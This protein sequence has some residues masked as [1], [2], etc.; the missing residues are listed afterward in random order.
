MTDT[1]I[2]VLADSMRSQQVPEDKVAETVA[3]LKAARSQKQQEIQAEMQAH[4]VRVAAATL[5]FA[6]AMTQVAANLRREKTLTE[7]ISD[8]FDL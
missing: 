2:A 5:Q 7:K 4:Q 8:W 3:A 6:V 1:E